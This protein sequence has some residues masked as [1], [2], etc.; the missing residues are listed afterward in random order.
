MK[1]GSRNNQLYQLFV[2]KNKKLSMVVER[3]NNEIVIRIPDDRVAFGPKDIQSLLDYIQYR[4]LVS[5]STATEKD[6]ERLSKSA[7]SN[8]WSNNK[9]RILGE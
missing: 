6:L 8:W 2:V 3:V 9:D 5:K 1:I 7:N 4:Q